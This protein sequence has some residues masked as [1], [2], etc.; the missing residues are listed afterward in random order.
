[1]GILVSCLTKT[2]PLNPDQHPDFDFKGDEIPDFE[3]VP[4]EIRRKLWINLVVFILL[5]VIIFLQIAGL[6][7]DSLFGPIAS[8]RDRIKQPGNDYA[9]LEERIRRAS[10]DGPVLADEYMAMLPKNKIPLY[11]QPFELTQLAEAGLWDQTVFLNAIEGRE[12]PLILIHHFQFYPV[13]LERW[14]PEM[15]E[16]VFGN[17]VAM[18]MRANSLLFEPKDTENRTYPIDLECP[19]TPFSLPTQAN[20]GIYWKDN[21]LLMLGDGRSGEIPVFAVADGLLYQF[22]E[23]NAAVAIQHEDPINPGQTLWSFYGDMAPAFDQTNPYIETQWQK[24]D[25]LPIKQGELIGYQGRWLGTSQQTWVHLRFA[26]LP[27]AEGGVFPEAFLPIDDFNADLPGM[28]EQQR[29]GLAG[30][31]SLTRYTGLP[32]SR[33]FGFL[34]FLPFICETEGD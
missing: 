29:L 15:R 4:T 3:S 24:A 28:E 34:D 9:F 33:F 22:P 17:Y 8:H 32:Q 23:W 21:Q 31:L 12:F 6:S 19:E 7:R 11:I 16:A 5:A 18:E 2:L 26:L 20:M 27:T 25:G 13:Y 10:D 30:P 1:M 14:T